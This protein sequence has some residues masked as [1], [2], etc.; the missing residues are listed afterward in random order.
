MTEEQPVLAGR[1]GRLAIEQEGAERRDA[2]A[3]TDHDD[4]RLR[5]LRQT[6]TVRLLHVDLELL[7]FSDA[8]A[9]EG[10]GNTDPLALADDVAHRIDRQRQFSRRRIVRGRDRVEPRLERL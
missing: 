5:I 6:E 1:A 7:A 10:R 8:L 3:G 4:R 9:E 2:G